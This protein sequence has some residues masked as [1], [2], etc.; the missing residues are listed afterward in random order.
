MI[1]PGHQALAA[2]SSKEQLSKH[3]GPIDLNDP[4]VEISGPKTFDEIAKEIAE[5]ENIP[6][7]Q[8]RN[9]VLSAVGTI[10]TNGIESPVSPEATGYFTLTKRITVTSTYKPALKF[11][12][13]ADYTPG[14][15]FRGIKKIVHVSMDRT[16]TNGVTKQF[17]GEVYAYLQD[18]NT[19]YYQINGDFFNNGSTSFSGSVNIGVR[20]SATVT[21]TVSGST[22]HYKYIWTEGYYYY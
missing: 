18:A 8:A 2:V 9:H 5:E 16:S 10:T 12:V 20:Q 22:N 15:S 3:F 11:R 6:I 13:Y 7:S 21:F 4:D 1:L 19:I 17:D 14:T